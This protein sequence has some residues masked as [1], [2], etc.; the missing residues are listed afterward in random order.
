V[1]D[2]TAVRTERLSLTATGPEDAEALAPIMADPEGWWY[3]PESRHTSPERT[4]AWLERAA[5]RWDEGLSY[6]TI[7]LAETGEVIGVGGAQRHFGGGWNL[8]YRIATGHWGKGYASEV[9]RAAIEAAHQVDPD[10]PVIA[11]VAAHNTPSRKVAERAGLTD[12]GE[13]LDTNDNT[14]RHAYADRSLGP[15][16]K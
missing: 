12:Q 8:S 5:E 16:T 13:R 15:A 9:T 11:W 4:T 1:D 7:R 14:V 6:W 2:V 3:E 10:A